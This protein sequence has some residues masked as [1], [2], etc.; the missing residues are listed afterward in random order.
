AA[1][2]GRRT[3]V[4]VRCD[5]R[6]RNEHRHRF[7]RNRGKVT[8]S[9]GSGTVADLLCTEPVAP[10]VYAFHGKVDTDRERTVAQHGAVVAGTDDNVVAPHHVRGTGP[11]LIREEAADQ[12]E[13]R[14]AA[15]WRRALHQRAGWSKVMKG[16]ATGGRSRPGFANARGNISIASP[17]PSERPCL[18]R[19]AARLL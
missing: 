18:A 6:D 16:N 19:S 8:Q 4:A 12:V 17:G 7:R 2:H 15:Q 10:E 11:V 1:Q 14:T 5:E 13:L 9:N 3:I